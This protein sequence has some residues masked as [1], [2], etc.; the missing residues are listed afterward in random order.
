M[1]SAPANT[2]DRR[3]PRRHLPSR[4][5][6]A[7]TDRK[8]PLGEPAAC[9]SWPCT[10]M[11]FVSRNGRPCQRDLQPPAKAYAAGPRLAAR[12]HDLARRRHL[13]RATQLGG[14]RGAGASMCPA[15]QTTAWWLPRSSCAG[16]RALA[17]PLDLVVRGD[18]RPRRGRRDYRRWWRRPRLGRMYGRSA[19]RIK[20]CG[21][22][23]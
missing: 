21:R 20:R 17:Q 19:T 22:T 10:R 6:L 1:G 5:P 4:E 14:S 13:L 7:R 16:R 23:G 3:L 2:G 8:D 11:R 9:K 12:H 15:G 18:G